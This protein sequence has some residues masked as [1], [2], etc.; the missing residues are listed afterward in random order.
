M[1]IVEKKLDQQQ[2]NP[3]VK[4]QL[5]D[6]EKMQEVY[7]RINEVFQQFTAGIQRIIDQVKQEEQKRLKG[8]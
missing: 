7:A 4:Y 5:F 8:K 1:I 2:F 3:Q 6:H